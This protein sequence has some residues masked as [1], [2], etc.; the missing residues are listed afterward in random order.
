MKKVHFLIDKSQIVDYLVMPVRYNRRVLYDKGYDVK[1][2]DQ[3]SKHCLSCDIL[4][5]ASKSVF[6]IVNDEYWTIIG[7]D[8][9]V[10]RLIEKAKKYANK[11]IWLDTSDSTSVTHFELLPH[12]DLYLKKQLLKDRNLYNKK[13]YGGR[14]FSDFYHKEFGIKDATL[15]N[16]YYPLDMNLSHKVSLSWNIGLGNV[17]NAFTKKGVIQQRISNV[18]P[19]GY[20]YAFHSAQEKRDMDIFIRTTSNLSRNVIAFHRQELLRRLVDITQEF[21]NLKVSLNEE[22]VKLKTF[23][24]ILRNTKILPS[25]F[26][27][28]ELGVRDYEAFIFGAALLKPNIS[29]METWPNIFIEK[30]TYQPFDWSFSDLKEAIIELLE[31]D[32][33]RIRIANNGQEKY[34]DSISLMGMELFCDWFVQQI[35]L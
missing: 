17:Y 31:D 27:W 12:V 1:V 29:H 28:G 4:L 26:G 14:I 24:S 32:E 19:T 2:F 13:Y 15:F 34:A 5:L 11:V 9:P 20:N 35:E 23:R 8:S 16:Q 6:S 18:F 30:D 22:K 3:P 33:L 10:F 21:E 7:P 25:P